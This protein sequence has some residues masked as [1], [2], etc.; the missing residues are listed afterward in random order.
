MLLESLPRKQLRYLFLLLCFAV[1]MRGLLLEQMD[2]IDP[3]EARYATVGVEMYLTGDWITPKLPNTE[4]VM[5]YLGKPPLH[6]WLTAGSYSLFGIEEWTSRLPSLLSSLLMLAAIYLFTRRYFDQATAISACLIAFSSGL[7]F[8]LAGASVTDVTLSAL[9]SLTAIFL[10]FAATDATEN[11]RNFIYSS[12][13]CALAFLCKGPIALVLS[14]LPLLLWSLVRQDFS[15]IRRL[16]WLRGCAVF[17]LIVTPWFLISELQQPGFLRYFFWNENIARYLFKEYGDKYGT[18]HVH[19]YGSI[20]VML[21]IAFCP[22]TFIMALQMISKRQEVKTWWQTNSHLTYLLCWLLST[23]LFFTFVRQLHAMYALPAIPPLAI[24]SA[25]FLKHT[26]LTPEESPATKATQPS[27]QAWSK[28]ILVLFWLGLVVAGAALKFETINVILSSLMLL[29]G[30][31]FLVVYHKNS[32]RFE[33]F[34]FLSGLTFITYFIV[35]LAGT[36]HINNTRS[37]EDILKALIDQRTKPHARTPQ[38]AVLTSNSYSHYWTARAWETE[39]GY[40]VS[41]RY[42][43]ATSLKHSNISHVLIRSAKQQDIPIE[44]TS[45]F[46]VL[47]QMNGWFLLKRKKKLRISLLPPPQIELH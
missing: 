45:S 11:V 1:A 28:T 12:I 27:W 6:F 15:W 31:S 38:L 37:A 32:Q 39:L 41:V 30:G 19:M 5:P 14:G 9:I 8:F 18:G 10:Y 13:F 17:M 22:W 33:N 2:L 20:W 23:P 7:F 36:P 40:P 43:E 44:V 3:T 34:G 21:L 26:F 46:K 25:T 47:N 29:A 24:L 42:M 4:G 35:I 16:A